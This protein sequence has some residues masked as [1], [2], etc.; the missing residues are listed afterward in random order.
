MESQPLW[1]GTTMRTNPIRNNESS[2]EHCLCPM[3]RPV[4]G[5]VLKIVTTYPPPHTF[6]KRPF[7]TDFKKHT[8]TPPPPGYRHFGALDQRLRKPCRNANLLC[9]GTFWMSQRDMENEK[10]VLRR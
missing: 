5:S 6:L 2:L 8:H 9:V 4:Y 10:V 1:K 3:S 7:R